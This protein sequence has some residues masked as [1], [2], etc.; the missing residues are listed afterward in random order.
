MRLRRDAARLDE[1]ATYLNDY[2]SN[3][4]RKTMMLHQ[5]L[6]EHFLQP[7]GRMLA[8]KTS[9]PEYANFV[10]RKARA[11]SAFD[12]RTRLQDTFL[13]QLPEIPTL[14]CDASEFSDPVKKYQANTEREERL[15]DLIALSTGQ[16][17]RR[18]A[19]SDRDTM[20]LKKW[21]ILAETRFYEGKDGKAPAKGKRVI[22]E[23][24]GSSLARELDQF[25][26]PEPRKIAARRSMPAASIDHLATDLH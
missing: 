18:H 1:V 21:K 10:A 14:R 25:A 16:Q 2:Q 24:F 5:E 11:V 9:G 8:R 15:T 19:P 17:P 4:E 3:H 20:N 26:P 12:T 13:E 7:L 6:E 22:A 23:R